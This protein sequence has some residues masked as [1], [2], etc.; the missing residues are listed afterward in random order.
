M[1]SA[2]VGSGTVVVVAFSPLL[3]RNLRG[4]L[5]M[6]GYSV[7]FA[8]METSWDQ[9]ALAVVQL[10]ILLSSEPHWVGERICEICSAI[11]CKAPNLP[12]IV[13]GRDD[14]ETKVRLFELGADDY[15]SG[16]LDHTELLARIKAQIRRQLSVD[17]KD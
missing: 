14:T 6:A 3:A 7:D 9:G 1:V 4:L 15:V 5:R 16:A 10:A 11:R 17:S 8:S 12:V 2:S 13:I